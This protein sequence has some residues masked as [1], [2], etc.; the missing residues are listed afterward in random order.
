MV[1]WE[2]WGGLIYGATLGMVVAMALWGR[3]VSRLGPKETMLYVYVEPVSAVM[4][5]AV[6]LGESL[7]LLQGLGAA[8]TFVA[9]WIAAAPWTRTSGD[10]GHP[11]RRRPRSAS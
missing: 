1:S 2:A 6:L 11:H 5:A 7:T 10:I 3:S 9:L 4:I 8:L